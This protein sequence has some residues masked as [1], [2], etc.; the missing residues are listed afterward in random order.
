MAGLYTRDPYKQGYESNSDEEDIGET[1]DEIEGNPNK[2]ILWA[3]EHNELDI[4]K[5]LL[6]EDPELVKSVDEDLYTPLHRA[7]YNGHLMMV[8]LLLTHNA[9]VHARTADGWQ[10]IHSACKWNNPAVASLLLQNGSDINSQTNG[11]QTP[12]HLAASNGKAKETL[13]L[14]LL[15]R[16]I[17][18]DIL[19][20]ANEKASDIVTRV[21]PLGYLFEMV[22]DHMKPSSS[23][24]K[25]G[26]LEH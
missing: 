18:P 20:A 23:F 7:S 6:E 21:G 14:L 13:E 17:D 2:K 24:S 10:P 15:N 3:A 12:L 22:E 1:L 9:S 19:N 4:A 11:G 5:E 26:K 25:T 8:E 16:N